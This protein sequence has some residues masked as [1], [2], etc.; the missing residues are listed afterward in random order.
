MLHVEIE[1]KL[2]E[3]VSAQQI[4]NKYFQVPDLL[5]FIFEFLN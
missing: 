3:Y 1:D 5:Y 2:W 4:A